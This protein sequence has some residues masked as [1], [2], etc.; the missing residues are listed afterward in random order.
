MLFRRF[1]EFI[2]EKESLE[3]TYTMEPDW[4][5]AWKEDNSEKFKIT[6]QEFYKLY[7][8]HDIGEVIAKYE[9]ET[10]RLYTN[11]G[12]EFFVN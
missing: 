12:F 2:N 4:W 1:S 5:E 8:I 7:Y 9:P 6:Y 11:K 10:N 3:K